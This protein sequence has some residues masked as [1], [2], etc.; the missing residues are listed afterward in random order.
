[1][2]TKIT[3]NLP[4]NAY[5]AAVNAD[6]PSAT[7]PYA[8]IN[9][10][11]TNTGNQLISGGA[12][13]SGTGLVFNVSVLVYL[14]AGIEYTTAET[15][16]TSAAGD[17]SNPRFDAIVADENQTVSIVQGTPAG[18]PIT[19]AISDDQ[20][21]VQYILIGAN[22]TAPTI[23]TE[24]I[25]QDD[26]S[27]HWLGA[28]AGGFGTTADF[29]STTPTPFQGTK[30]TLATIGR[31]GGRRG[32]NFSTGTPV[33]RS[34]Y[35]LL[36]FRINLPASLSDAN[37]SY[38]RVFAYSDNTASPGYLGWAEAGNY[39]DFSLTNAWQLVTI[40]TALFTSNMGSVTTIGY[41]NFTLYRPGST[42]LNPTAQIA[43][44]DIKL[45]TGYGPQLNIATIDLANDNDVVGSTSKVDFVSLPGT[46]NR[47][48]QDSATGIIKV[49]PNAPGL[50]NQTTAGA[51]LSVNVNSITTVTVDAQ[52]AN[53]TIALPTGNAENGQKLVFRIKDDGTARAI[54]WNVVF[55]AIGVTLPTTTTAGKTLYVGCMYNALSS[56]W[57][58]IAVT[59]EA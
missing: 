43:L 8:T 29:L 51:T 55:Q 31:Y 37:I 33:S 1:M 6:S 56:K 17:P 39:V 15:S 38:F 27:T 12:S 30:C 25:Y 49:Q 59:E 13:Y 7:N 53:F 41:L 50:D 4:N 28:F 32:V 14:I 57:D 11:T 46:S 35:V 19:P 58:V 3:R 21:L 52:D 26:G 54:T 44:D 48:Q 45:Q 24:L 5:Q 2:T 36:S 22:A 9:D 47:L 16:V 20:V 10:L 42:V 34:E 18:T 23:N 40:P